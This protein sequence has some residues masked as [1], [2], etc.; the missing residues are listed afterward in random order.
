[1]P[2]LWNDPVICKIYKQ[3]LW[4]GCG[5]SAVVLEDLVMCSAHPAA[6]LGTAE[7]GN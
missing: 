3:I 5:G 6:V 7:S 2:R 1:M 4:L